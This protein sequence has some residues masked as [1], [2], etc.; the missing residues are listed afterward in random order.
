MF[1]A[2]QQ[3]KP[4]DVA[5]LVDLGRKDPAWWVRGVLGG[6]PWSLQERILESVRDNSET[7]VP[8]CH[9]TGK[10]WIAARVALWF[11]GREPNTY[12]LVTAPTQR[13]VRH[14]FWSEL[15]KAYQNARY[16]L[17][18]KLQVQMLFA[19]EDWKILAF[20]APEWDPDKFAGFHAMHVL[21]I[22][23]EASGIS[24]RIYTAMD[25]ILS[26]GVTRR[27]LY[28]GNPLDPESEFSKIC[29]RSNVNT[30]HASAFD[31]PNFT[32]AGITE[33]DIA[34]GRWRRKIRRHPALRPYLVQPDWVADKYDKWGPTSPRYQSRVLG[35][36][37][38]LS[39]DQ[40]I[41]SHVV[42][43]AIARS[44]RPEGE[45]VLSADV[46]RLGNDSN[47]IGERRGYVARI[48]DSTKKR[49][50]TDTAGR[51]AYHMRRTG[52]ERVQI[53]ED[54]VGGPVLDILLEMGINAVGIKFAGEA[55]EKERFANR[56]A[57]MYHYVQELGEQGNL[58]LPDDDDL[59]A[60]LTSV[61]IKHFNSRG[62]IVLEEKKEHKRRIGSSPDRADAIVLL[63]A[64]PEI[65]RRRPVV[66]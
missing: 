42:A 14:V 37:P 39:E 66:W 49:R 22:F 58:D 41:T 12:V 57:E 29:A 46:A 10:D 25:G 28:I 20:T 6:D 15:S 7:A 36:F 51:I 16:P 34:S 9:G 55:V 17:G 61:R 56:R 32:N 63:F 24:E 50:A 26:S 40:V 21:G 53:D 2:A 30:I 27:R 59:A 33:V 64:P 19:D 8:T 4:K 18:G 47:V 52:A 1:S 38:D 3:L 23:D 31:T 62:Q 60:E 35:R 13:Q 44:L 45:H 54:G 5:R 11:F 43:A 65:I 48:I